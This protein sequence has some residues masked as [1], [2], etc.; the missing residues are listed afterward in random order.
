MPLIGA[1]HIAAGGRPCQAA[2]PALF[3][4]FTT[5][6]ATVIWLELNI[7]WPKKVLHVA[8]IRRHQSPR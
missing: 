8:D 6:W 2:R 1:G 4:W 5:T 3:R 7:V